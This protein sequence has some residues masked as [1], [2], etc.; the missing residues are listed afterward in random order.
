VYW[1]IVILVTVVLQ[2]QRTQG[3]S[4]GRIMRLVGISRHTLKRWIHYFN[5]VFPESGRW[6]RIRGRM[7]VEIDMGQIPSAIIL[8]FIERF[9][10]AEDGLISSLQ[11]F[12]GGLGVF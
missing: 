5:E 11:L 2:Q 12:S 7:G 3:Y 1:S 8:F 9:G 4:A 6:K 10:S